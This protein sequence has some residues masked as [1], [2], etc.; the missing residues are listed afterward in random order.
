M[1]ISTTI[2]KDAVA[3][4]I[5][6]SS[7]NNNLPLTSMIGIKLSGGK[8]RLLST[9]MVNTL[10]VIIDKVAGDDVDITVSADLF[11]KLISKV[12][13]ESVEMTVND[14]VLNVK[15][16]GS[17]KIPIVSDENGDVSFPDITV[18]TTLLAPVNVKLT[19]ILNVFN[20]NR[21]SLLDSVDS[22]L[23][24][25]MCTNE[26]V[27]STNGGIL[28][29]NKLR[30]FGDDDLLIP[31]QMMYLLTLNDVEDITMYTDG[32]TLYFVTDNLIVAGS[33]LSGKEE[34]PVEDIADYFNIEFNS[35]CKVP[36]ELL[37]SVID[38]LMLFISSFDKNC[39]TFTFTR[40][41]INISSKAGSSDELIRYVGSENFKEF[42]CEVNIPAFKKLV[43][44]SPLDTIT[45]YY[46]DDSVIAIKDGNVS[47][48]LALGSDDEIEYEEED[49]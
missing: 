7:N 45:L 35:S 31:P 14:G 42:S 8:L 30:L 39:A 13:S 29:S 49:E 24:G 16:N 18:D 41:G 10:C 15:A 19:S 23:G 34:Y 27:I 40:T 26:A 11:S 6:G 9:D 46:G 47:Q 25:Y 28:T 38:R 1:K 44:A 17:Y 3:K 48:I 37:L 4:S 20:I 5:K 33:E 21:A 32:N 22:P 43:S 2:L 36:R 12:T